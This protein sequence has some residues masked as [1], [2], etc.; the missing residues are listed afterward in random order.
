MFLRNETFESFIKSYKVVT[1]LVIIHIFFYIWIYWFPFLGGEEIYWLGIGNNTLVA[2][3]DFWRLVTPIFLHGGLTHMLFNSFSLVLFGPA[4]ETM[5]GRLKFITAYLATGILANIAF[6]FLG[7]PRV[8]HLGASGA[9]FGLFGIY[10]YM[11]LLRKDLINRM[12]SQLIMTIV[13]IGV[14]MT[15]LNPGVNIL[16]HLFGLIAGAAIAPLFL[17]GVSIYS[18]RRPVHDSDEVSFDPNRWAKRNH[19][20]KNLIFYVV[21]GF[22]GMVLFFYLVSAFLL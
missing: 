9:I 14:I 5:L 3:G 20:K 2:S 12:N 21:G 7:S 18:Q 6:Y 19:F 11:V 22:A 13:A 15:F 8:I 16:A 4:L 17:N 10:V 1:S